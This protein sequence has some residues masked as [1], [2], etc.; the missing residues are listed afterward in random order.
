M[1]RELARRYAVYVAGLSLL[2]AMDRP[3][4][5]AYLLARTAIE[6]QVTRVAADLGLVVLG[7]ALCLA[8][9]KI[10]ALLKAKRPLGIAGDTLTCLASL[11]MGLHAYFGA[12]SP[13]LLPI[14]GFAFSAGH[15]MLIAAWFLA[16]RAL[17]S[18]RVLPAVLS[19]FALSM[20]LVVIDYLPATA[21]FACIVILPIICALLVSL[22]K[23]DEL[24][25]GLLEQYER[26]PFSSAVLI[27]RL[28]IALLFAETFGASLIRSLWAHQGIGYATSQAAL[29][30]YLI[31]LCIALLCIAICLRSEY[32]EKGSL[33]INI[34]T[35]PILIV[36]SFAFLFLDND[37]VAVST[38]TSVSS[39]AAAALMGMASIAYRGERKAYLTGAGLY[40]VILGFTMFVSYSL[41]PRLI[42]FSGSAPSS[43]AAPVIF[44]AICEIM[45]VLAIAF[46][47]MLLDNARKFEE[48]QQHTTA[49]TIVIKA[50]RPQE[51]EQH[52]DAQPAASA[53]SQPNT[54]AT[55]TGAD[56][57]SAAPAA[58]PA[59]PAAA[60]S[61]P[62]DNDIV[63]AAALLHYRL[64]ENFGLTQREADIAELLALGYT[65]KRVADEL[66]L[67]A[68]TVQSYTKS[69]YRKMGVHKKDEL[70]EKVSSLRDTI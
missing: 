59:E 52:A 24:T 63:T 38:V 26:P 56:D 17:P 58:A 27:D 42:N 69:I 66:V 12:L 37:A 19:A 49:R 13:S 33:G 60:N 2:F 5:L 67:S 30:T 51:D 18:R 45:L 22:T 15:T 43:A 28:A 14:A 57:E 1:N 21:R 50:A 7:I 31:S 48:W 64:C 54:N 65:A 23:D 32:A 9:P 39:V 10:P 47:A 6:T 11:I 3:P 53:E 55:A 44:A 8:A 40:A 35:L 62:K 61:S 29:A 41:I 34:V 20:S 16:S 70:I 36:A 68:S 46:G 4:F 25:W